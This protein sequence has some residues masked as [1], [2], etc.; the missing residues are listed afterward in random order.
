MTEEDHNNLKEN[1]IEYLVSTIAES[2]GIN[3]HITVFGDQKNDSN[4]PSI[5]HIMIPE[6][7]MK[8]E[9]SKDEFVDDVLPNVFKQLKKKFKVHSIAWAA[10][11]WMRVVGKDTN[12]EDLKNWKAIPIKK[13]VIIVTIETKDSSET[14]MYNI[15]RKGK[16]VTKDGD[17]IDDIELEKEDLTEGVAVG[18][19]FSGL[20]TKFKN[21]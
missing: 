11:A 18:G 14:L 5:I 3:P 12:E 21:I 10:E 16:K 2:G 17:F 19:R 4:K 13:E 6:E 20:F 15:I 1:Y 7:F 9:D 8:S